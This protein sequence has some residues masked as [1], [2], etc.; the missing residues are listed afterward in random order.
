QQ[1]G[2]P[3][4]QPG[5]GRRD[6]LPRVLPAELV[7]R[8]VVLAPRAQGGDRL[9]ERVGQLEETV[10]ADDGDALASGMDVL[11][12]QGGVLAHRGGTSAGP[13]GA[14]ASGRLVTGT[15][16]RPGPQSG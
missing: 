3:R 2:R 1:R 14:P 4:P 8:E 7:Q 5:P 10:V 13:Q 12:R 6:R 16:G 9:R 11:P 15:S